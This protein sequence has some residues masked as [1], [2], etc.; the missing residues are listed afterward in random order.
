MCGVPMGR[1]NRIIR[2]R[3]RRLPPMANALEMAAMLGDGRARFAH[4][5]DDGELYITDAVLGGIWKFNGC[6]FFHEG[7]EAHV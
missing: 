2:E 4:R 1:C 7:A 3:K 6:L 5:E